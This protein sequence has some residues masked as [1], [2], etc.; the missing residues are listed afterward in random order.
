[1]STRELIVLGSASQL[2]TRHRNHNGYLLRWD[3]Q[4]LLFDPGEGTQRQMLLAGVSV[5]G[6]HRLCI[7]HFHGDHCLGVPGLVQRLSVDGVAHPVWAYFPASGRQLFT[8]LRYACVF[9]E[10]ADLREVPVSG[11]GAVAMAS[12]GVLEARRLDHSIDAFGYRLVEPD[13]RRLVPELLARFGI[14]GPAVGELQ[15]AGSIRAGGRRVRLEEVSQPRRGQRFAFIMDTRLCDAVY[16]LADGADLLVIEATF[17][18]EDSE[19]AA[20]YGH[21]TAQQ[22]ATVAAECGVRRLVLT[23]FSQRYPDTNRYAAQ[24][25]EVFSG[26]LVI[27]ED[28]ARIPVPARP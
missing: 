13:G 26:D 25:A 4:G 10:V 16:A 19:L 14:E 9:H 22:A 20:R 24:A 1:M 17:L 28:F 3:G 7:T 8:R 6:V 2:P 23:H 15:R 5:N 27:A 11:D 12:F 18:S 21:L